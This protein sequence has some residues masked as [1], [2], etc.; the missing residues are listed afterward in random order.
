MTSVL[1]TAPLAGLCQLVTDGTHD[2]PK[3]QNEGVP[4]IKGK[5]ISGGFIDFD[6]CDFITYDDHL[7]VISRSKPEQGD[8]LLSNIGSV[9][10]V[11]YV[12]TVREFS[13]KNVALFKPDREKVDPRYMYYLLSSPIVRDGL[14]SH[15]SSSAQPFISL[16]VLRGYEV[17]YHSA[18]ST[19]RRIASI[20]SAYDDLIENNARRIAILAEI[21]RRLYEEWFVHLRFPGHEGV[22]MAEGEIGPV[23]EGWE[24][25]RLGQVADIRWGDTNTT[26]KAYIEEGFDAYSASG[27]DGKLDHFDFDRDGIVLSAIGAHCGRA[28][29]ARGK[30]SCIKNT[31]RFWSIDD[32]VSN[33]HLYVA[34][35]THD[36]WPRRGAAQPFISQTDARACKILKASVDVEMKFHEVVEPCLTLAH[37]LDRKNTNLR[38]QRDLLLP[39]LISGEIDASEIGEQTAE[40]AAE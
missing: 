21:T 13:I 34:T 8:T 25:V 32:D 11:A 20:L 40:A 9:G 3:L 2:S 33:E 1:S 10:D 17:Q 14:L 15:R 37:R 22:K 4:F 16:G 7:I 6:N 5:H 28:W 31:I 27:L 24:V 18:L 26:K 36:F 30:W 19:Q 35:S 23:P 29:F 39:K 38:T 12:N